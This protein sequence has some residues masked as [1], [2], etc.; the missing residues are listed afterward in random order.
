MHTGRLEA[1]SDGV[2][3]IIITIMVLELH[4]PMQPTLTALRPMVPAFL[5][6]VLSFVFVGIYWNNHHHM[7]QLAEKING[8]ALWANLMLLFWLSLV[9]FNTAWLGNTHFAKWPVFTYGLLLLLSGVSYGWMTHILTHDEPANA[10]LAEAVGEDR[11]G[12]ISV[13]LYATGMAMELI[14][15]GVACGIY[16]LV[17]LIWLVPDR[18]IER[19]LKKEEPLPTAGS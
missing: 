11:K 7:F 3:A 14:L 2:F 17:A 19:Q 18:R 5:S 16:V 9:P 1:F 13:V 4:A 15:P 10:C 8:R 12:I 6:Y